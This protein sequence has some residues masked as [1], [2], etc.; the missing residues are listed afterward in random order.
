[1]ALKG[2]KLTKEHKEKI[3]NSVRKPILKIAYPRLPVEL[4]RRRKLSPEQVTEILEMY[5]TG[6]SADKLASLYS[7]STDTIFRYIN[8]EKTV[9]KER[10]QNR[11]RRE[12]TKN[13]L[14]LT[15]KMLAYSKKSIAYRKS[16]MGKKWKDWENNMCRK[17]YRHET[18]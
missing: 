7:V 18:N 11:I 3:G 16:I 13:D 15:K 5:S 1:M 6:T 14:D 17:K 9:L 8:Y 4:D 12:K 10:E 2:K